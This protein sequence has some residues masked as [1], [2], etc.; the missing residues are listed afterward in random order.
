MT[1]SLLAPG[2]ASIPRAGAFVNVARSVSIPVKVVL[3]GFNE[4]QADTTYLSWSE[5]Y[6]NLPDSITDID[7]M[8]RHRTGVGCPS[9]CFEPHTG[10]R[11]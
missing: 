5:T 6:K 10:G 1:L 4:Q 2:F 8:S 3:V 7:L 11:F 9:Y